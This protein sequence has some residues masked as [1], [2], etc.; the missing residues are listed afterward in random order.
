MC[1]TLVRR[2][3]TWQIIGDVKTTHRGRGNNKPIVE[4]VVSGNY[5]ENNSLQA[6]QGQDGF[7]FLEPNKD[8]RVNLETDKG[9]PLNLEA[10]LVIKFR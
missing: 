5:S 7:E 3:E 2:K 9:L 8:G 6:L 10:E 1:P 4:L